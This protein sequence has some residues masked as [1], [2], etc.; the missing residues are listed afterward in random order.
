MHVL[1]CAGE[2]IFN[3]NARGLCFAFRLKFLVQII[4]NYENVI[5]ASEACISLED[6]TFA[7]NWLVQC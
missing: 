2:E 5:S 1:S 3:P 6:E 4:L 7:W